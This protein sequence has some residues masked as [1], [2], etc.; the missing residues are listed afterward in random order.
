MASHDRLCLEQ[1]CYRKKDRRRGT[2]KSKPQRSQP[3]PKKSGQI[4]QVINKNK[5]SEYMSA[6]DLKKWIHV[7]LVFY[8]KWAKLQNK[9]DSFALN[10]SQSKRMS[11]KRWR[12]QSV[13][14]RLTFLSR[15][16]INDREEIHGKIFLPT[17][18]YRYIHTLINK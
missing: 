14:T 9:L 6:Y 11:S 12:T 10:A 7:S 5:S 1:I 4:T 2:P 17:S 13:S 8:K 18:S 16:L 3:V 15:Q